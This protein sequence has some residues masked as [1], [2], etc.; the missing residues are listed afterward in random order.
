MDNFGND[1]L[2]GVANISWFST[3]YKFG[4]LVK[5]RIG[6]PRFNDYTEFSQVEGNNWQEVW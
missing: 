2:T 4:D 6:K 1:A 5:L 3:Y